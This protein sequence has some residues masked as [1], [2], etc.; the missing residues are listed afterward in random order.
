MLITGD[1]GFVVRHLAHELSKDEREELNGTDHR[2]GGAGEADETLRCHL[3]SQRPLDVTNFEQ[4]RGC[5]LESSPDRVV[6]LAAQASGSQSLQR[7]AETYKVNAIGALNVLEAVR[8]EAPQ[9]VGLLIGTV[10]TYRA[11]AHRR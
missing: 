3:K 11:V 8:L 5:L 1:A 7:P 2:V 10:D 4:V 6:H 9:A